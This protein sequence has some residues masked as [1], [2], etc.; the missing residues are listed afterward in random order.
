MGG[1]RFNVLAA[2]R[3]FL[4]G[5]SKDY[6]DALNL[7]PPPNQKQPTIGVILRAI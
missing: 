3:V 7:G 4:H 1:D 2:V 6:P 5:N